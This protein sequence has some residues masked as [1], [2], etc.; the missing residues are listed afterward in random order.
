MTALHTH[1]NR[2]MSLLQEEVY[3]EL[4]ASIE[5]EFGTDT[6]SWREFL[7]TKAMNGVIQR[8]GARV[9][10]GLPICRDEKW[11]TT[12]E[13]T[14]TYLG[15]SMVSGQFIPWF[16]QPVIS[17]FLKYICD[18]V[19]DKCFKTIEPI[20]ES[21]YSQILREQHNGVQNANVPYNLATSLTRASLNT[22]DRKR[23]DITTKFTTILIVVSLPVFLFLSQKDECSSAVG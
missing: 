5:H 7:I 12:A 18:T 21:W 3:D 6:G 20:F 1:V 22:G 13:R 11:L 9:V 10:F 4:R 19:R 15:L 2:H 8:V 16:I 17:P 23:V 14:T